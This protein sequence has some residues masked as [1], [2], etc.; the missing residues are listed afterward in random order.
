MINAHFSQ[1]VY[2]HMDETSLS[3]SANSPIS[4]CAAFCELE[5]FVLQG[6]FAEYVCG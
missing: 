4:L 2:F 5:A 6:C 3:L 1:Y